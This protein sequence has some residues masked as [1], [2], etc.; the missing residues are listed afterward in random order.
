MTGV[1]RPHKKC[2]CQSECKCEREK[3]RVVLIEGAP[4][5]GKTT[6][7]Q[8]LAYDWSVGDTTTEFSFPKVDMLLRLTC[9]DMK[10]AKIEDAIDDQLLPLEVEKTDKEKFFHYIRS[11]Q[12]R[13]LF[14]LDGLDELPKNLFE[15]FLPFIKGK[16][17]PFSYLMLTA[18]HEAGMKLR[19]H[20]DAL[21]EI[22]GYT[23]E[24]ADSYIKKYFSSHDKPSLAEELID[25]I[26]KDSKLRKLTANPLNT[27]L[28]C[29]VF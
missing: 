24:D 19:R 5:V 12:S 22:S 27:A 18:R 15:E 14:M 7:C 25:A 29:L 21:F 1:F 4:G 10:T 9:R 23:E 17:F 3:P 11:N 2:E 6:Y 13:I 16:V 26:D 8:K 28:L 20:C